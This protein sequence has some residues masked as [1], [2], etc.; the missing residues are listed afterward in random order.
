M[1]IA[2]DAIPV[3]LVEEVQGKTRAE[4][5]LEV[6]AKARAKA[7]LEAVAAANPNSKEFRYLASASSLSRVK[8]TATN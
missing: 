3:A 2:T 5:D 1:E 7:V 6:P 8:K 4:E